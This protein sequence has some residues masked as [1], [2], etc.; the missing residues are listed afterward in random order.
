MSREN[1]EIVERAIAALNERDIDAYLACCTRDI[2]VQTPFAALEGVFEGT[3]GIRQYWA[4]IEDAA[5]DLRLTVERLE[6]IGADRVLTFM[7]VI[8]TGRASSVPLERAT[9]NV[10]DLTDGKIRRIRIFL[11]RQEALEAAGLGK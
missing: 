6:S 9:A 7:H 2:Q 10:Y 5:P 11:D 8:A 1:V 4:N 3:A